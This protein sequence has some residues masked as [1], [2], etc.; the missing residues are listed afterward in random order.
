MR[1][2]C[3]RDCGWRFGVLLYSGGFFNGIGREAFY[4]IK[5]TTKPPRRDASLPISRVNPYG[6]VW[7]Y[8]ARWYLVYMDGVQREKEVRWGEKM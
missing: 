8:E 4:S 3:F 7:G 2:A 5:K 1:V 6:D